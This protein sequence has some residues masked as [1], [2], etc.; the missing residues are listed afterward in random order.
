MR[1]RNF[2][3]SISLPEGLEQRRD[4]HQ[5]HSLLHRFLK[6]AARRPEQHLHWHANRNTIK[7]SQDFFFLSWESGAATNVYV[8]ATNIN[9]YDINDDMTTLCSVSC[10]RLLAYMDIIFTDLHTGTSL[11]TT[12]PS[13]IV[14]EVHLWWA[15]DRNTNCTS[16]AVRRT[17]NLRTLSY[18]TKIDTMQP[19]RHAVR[20]LDRYSV[21]RASVLRAHSMYANRLELG[22][23]VSMAG[24]HGSPRTSRLQYMRF[25]SIICMW[26]IHDIWQYVLLLRDTQ[27]DTQCISL[28]L[29]WWS[30]LE[31]WS[32]ENSGK[33]VRKADKSLWTEYPNRWTGYGPKYDTYESMNN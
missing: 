5:H 1:T 8:H 33:R 26:Y 25:Q 4:Q 30:T 31:V 13:P 14:Q 28:H 19:A 6:T 22:R 23:A 27:G 20:V 24:G 3:E 32:G 17:P 9:N 18:T 29:F 10:K 2:S 16:T 15:C 21:G 12:K 7:D 11:M